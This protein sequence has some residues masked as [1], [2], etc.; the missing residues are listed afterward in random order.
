M[1]EPTPFN[2][3]FQ[4]IVRVVFLRRVVEVGGTIGK[5]ALPLLRNHHIVASLSRPLQ[6]NLE[7]YFRLEAVACLPA[8]ICAETR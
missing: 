7:Q 3:E 4:K 8:A 2:L 6:A 1:A 5:V